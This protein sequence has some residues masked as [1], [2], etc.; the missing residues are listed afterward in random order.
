M[1][2]ILAKKQFKKLPVVGGDG[3]LAGVIRPKSLMEHAS[4]ALFPKDDR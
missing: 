4:D 3:R 2:R 1:A